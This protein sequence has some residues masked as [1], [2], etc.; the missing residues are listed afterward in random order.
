MRI[1]QSPFFIRLTHWEYWSSSVL[2]IPIAFYFLWLSLKSRSLFFFSASNPGIDTGGLYG[3]SKMSVLKKIPK[4][5]IPKTI[6]IKPQTERNL[7]LEKLRQAEI[8]FPLIAKPD[9]GERGFLVEKMDDIESLEKHLARFPVDFILQ[10]YLDYEHEFNVLFYLIPGEETGT[11]SSI[12]IKKYMTV[13][14]DGKSSVEELMQK[15]NRSILQLE[16]FKKE[17]V[18]LMQEIPAKGAT[19]RIEP[20]GNHARG[21]AF[22]DGRYLVDEQMLRTFNHIAKQIPDMFIFRF[23]A[24]CKTPQGLKTGESLKFVEVNGAGG[25]PTHIYETGYSLFRAWGDLLH[26]WSIIYKVSSINHKNGVAY[27]SLHEGIAK[28]KTYFYYKEKLSK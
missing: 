2:Y 7:L 11:I 1:K 10:E 24:K 17:K 15:D 14:G 21:T 22:F 16:R 20:V 25:E 12:T 6:L 3:E 23:D 18:Q 5:F 27:M 19:L 28:L 8:E 9:V 13:I 4:E 26:Q